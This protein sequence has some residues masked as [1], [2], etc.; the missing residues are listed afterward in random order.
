M[1]YLRGLFRYFS[2]DSVNGTVVQP[3]FLVV[4]LRIAWYHYQAAAS[5]FKD[6]VRLLL[7][8]CL[9]AEYIEKAHVW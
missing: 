7:L 5:V 4:S 3:T 9:C 1:W 6:E 8:R 2:K